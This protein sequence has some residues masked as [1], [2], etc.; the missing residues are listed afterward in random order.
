MER[1]E[2]KNGLKTAKNIAELWKIATE[3]FHC[4]PSTEIKNLAIY[5]RRVEAAVKLKG[6]SSLLKS[7]SIELS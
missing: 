1:D 6:N 2:E 7:H 4:I 5:A 3:E